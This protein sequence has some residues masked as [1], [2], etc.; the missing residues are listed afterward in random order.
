MSRKT[1]SSS[2]YPGSDRPG[3][4][5]D[6]GGRRRQGPGLGGL[7]FLRRSNPPA[8]TSRIAGLACP[9]C[10]LPIQEPDAARL[11]FCPRCRDFTGMCGAGR[12]IICPDLMT[13]TSWHMP[14]T[15][16]GTV[17]WEITRGGQPLITRLCDQHDA[18][19]GAAG[20]AWIGQAVRR[21]KSG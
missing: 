12:K 11:G 20:M 6:D 8:A 10:G 21:A 5:A 7:G 15:S 16:L 17:E 19:V 3:G 4:T 14:C 1:H 18:Q 13:V 9:G 2:T